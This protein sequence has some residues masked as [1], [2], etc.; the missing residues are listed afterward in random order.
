MTKE[1]V[2]RT[3]GAP[4]QT[5]GFRAGGR[6]VVVWH[7]LLVGPQGRRLPTPLVFEAGRLSGWGDNYYRQR[8]REL[9]GQQP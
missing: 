7:Y 6:A 1:E 8:L 3:L 4:E 5:E 2:R 9:G